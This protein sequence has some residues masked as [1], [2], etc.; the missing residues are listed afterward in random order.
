MKKKLQKEVCER[1]QNLSEGEKDKN[2]YRNFSE[3]E[4]EK[5]CQ[6]GINL[7]DEYRKFFSKMQEIRTI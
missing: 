6:Y 7:E 1:Y 2:R 3:E 4:K 5:N